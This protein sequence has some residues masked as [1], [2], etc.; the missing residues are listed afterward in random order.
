MAKIFRLILLAVVL[1]VTI[2]VVSFV[3]LKWW[4][5]LLIVFAMIVAAL[6]GLRY[7]ISNIGK[8]LGKAMLKVFEVKSKVLR[9]ATADVNSVQATTAPPLKEGEEPPKEAANYYR[10]DVTI[11]P[12]PVDGPMQHWDLDDLQLVPFDTP[13]TSLEKMAEEGKESVD[14][15]SLRETKVLQ[16]GEFV[17]DSAGKYQG[18]QQVQA[19]VA[20]PPH[21][22][23]LKFQYY[24]EQF[25]RI[26]LPQPLP[27]L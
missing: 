3:Y 24:A 26:T 9:G 4:Q 12:A 21:V 19:L 15:Y 1:F 10:I 14:G 2:T 6:L 13:A 25:G 22:R 5:A 23:E 20:V 18:D 11:K 27:L 8:F 16:D 17:D 7:L